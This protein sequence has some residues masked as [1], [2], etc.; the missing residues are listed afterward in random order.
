LTG[1]GAGAKRK[2]LLARILEAGSTQS[3]NR[4]GSIAGGDGRR[5]VML[6]EW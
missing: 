2:R 4:G 5:G 6:E 1:K 3:P